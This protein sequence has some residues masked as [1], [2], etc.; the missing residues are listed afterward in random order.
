MGGKLSC[1]KCGDCCKSATL[2]IDKNTK[3]L[4]WLEYHGMTITPNGNELRVKVPIQ[5]GKLVDNKCSIYDS[6]P[7]T[8]RRYMCEK[9]MLDN[10]KEQER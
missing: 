2:I 5:C 10:I 9:N 4:E 3:N 6:R 7:D 8:C 1:L